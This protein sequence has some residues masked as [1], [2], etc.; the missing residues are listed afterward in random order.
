M[1]ATV[2]WRGGE[3]FVAR[4]EH[5]QDVA[6][7]GAV[8]SPMEGLLLAFGACGGI[9]VV[10][11]LRKMRQDVTGYELR[12]SGEQRAEHPRVFTRIHVEH[13]VRGRG[14]DPVKVRRAV[15]LSAEYCPVGAT[16][17]LAAEVTETVQV[18]AEDDALGGAG[19]R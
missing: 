17:R 18:L 6:F 5:G 4:G 19:H 13:L 3:T 10:G 2:E 14:L 9:S 11:L 16:L 8:L 7:D 1:R 12:L 15:D